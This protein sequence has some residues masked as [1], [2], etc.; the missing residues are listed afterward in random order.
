MARRH[1]VLP[2]AGSLVVVPDLHGCL[3]DFE[4]A[5]RA[6]LDRHKASS[7]GAH[8]VFLGDVVHGPDETA[9]VQEPELYG[10][11]DA[12]MAIVQG[13]IELQTRFPGRVLYVL[14]NHDQGHVGGP[15]TR[16]FHPDEV[17]YLESRL[18]ASGL[19]LL[20]GFF[21]GAL[22]AVAAPCGLLLT[23]G[24]PTASFDALEELDRISVDPAE[25]EPD[26]NQVLASL[27][28][29]YGQPEEVTAR[30]LGALS[31]PDLPLAVVV[32][33]HDRDSSGYFI[34]GRNQLC[35]CIFGAPRA[36]KRYL[37]VDL[38]C[39][40]QSVEDLRDGHEI[41]ALYPAHAGPQEA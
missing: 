12:S 6:F 14:G 39:P 10:F 40:V 32:H 2:R 17:E 20:R 31:R 38:A 8:L 25:N 23:H 35:L 5:R 3:E 4:H 36:A 27:L 34:E 24:S 30:L 41:R 15:H 1:H 16:K 9:Q 11:P 13:I 18:D 21:A 22:L 28:T 26:Q 19:T 37:E 7:H 29:H 33:G